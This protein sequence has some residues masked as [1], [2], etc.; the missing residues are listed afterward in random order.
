MQTMTLMPV[1][2][3]L[4]DGGVGA[5]ASGDG[6]GAAAGEA[7]AGTQAIPGSSRRGKQSG[8]E[9]VVYGRQPD[10]E[11]S[12][13]SPDAGG[14]STTDTQTTS[15]TLE[16]RKARYREMLD[17]EFKDI[18]TEETQ[19]LINQRFKETKQLQEAL[20]AQGPVVDMLMSRYKIQNGDM[21]ALAQAI[22]ND[23]AY[24]SEAAEEA[25][26]S[27]EQFKNYQRMQRENEALRR[28]QQM[29]QGEESVNRQMQVWHQEAE[30][31]KETY[32]GFD[33]ATECQNPQFLSM[34]KNG[35][36]VQHAY[37][38][39]HLDDIKNGVA[40]DASKQTERNVVE[41][42]R[43]KGSRPAENGASTQSGVVVKSDVSKLTKADRM[44]I[45]R[46]AARG[47]M[48]SF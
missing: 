13:E 36:P 29:R 6:A 14:E 3:D 38:V 2:L 44:E 35:I 5:A 39:T 8:G 37:E 19:R 46:R 15:D 31:I 9:T 24:W 40:R 45:A 33:F 28:Y 30:A 11:V 41:G 21:Q 16:D 47:E 22:E 32:P 26:M 18:H 25:G 4:F 27:V 34:L 10:A 42:I 17:G 43:N 1:M 20:A 12:T 48:I 7:Q 23:S